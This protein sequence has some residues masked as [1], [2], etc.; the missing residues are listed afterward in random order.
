M[1]DPVWLGPFCRLNL[2]V[3][4]KL[5]CWNLLPNWDGIRRWGLWEVIKSWGWSPHFMIIARRKIYPRDSFLLPPCEVIGEGHL[6]VSNQALTRHWICE[7]NDFGLSLQNCE[8]QIS[9]G[10]ALSLWY[11]CESS[12]L[13]LRQA[14][15]SPALLQCSAHCPTTTLGHV[16]Q[17][18]SMASHLLKVAGLILVR[19]KSAVATDSNM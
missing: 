18:S 5:I 15:M 2:H 3:Y 4:P 6:W 10:K 7:H 8:K 12:L 1:S 19:V 17:G 11:F 14:S 13:G 9:V 16:F